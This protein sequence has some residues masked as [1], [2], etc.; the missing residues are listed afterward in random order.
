MLVWVASYPRSGNTFLRVLL[1]H[2]YGHSTYSVYGDPVL[3]EMGADEAVGHE[4]LMTPIDELKTS[5]EI[6]FVKTHELPD[7][8]SPALYLVRDG[9]DAVVSH[10]RYRLSFVKPI[11]LPGGGDFKAVLKDVITNEEHFGGWGRHV[12]SWTKR[13]NLSTVRFEDLVADPIATLARGV[14]DLGLSL[15]RIAG[16]APSFEELH[17]K[18]P[19][20]FRKGQSGS[21]REEM[22]WRLHRIFWK[23]HGHAMRL[24]GYQR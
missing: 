17:S 7:D 4:T 22:P 19:R 11:N 18:W 2:L 15:E 8:D 23:R 5:E 1:K 6:V 13:G 14:D 3:R 24:L 10:A 21:W 9:R 16:E 12:T 20:F